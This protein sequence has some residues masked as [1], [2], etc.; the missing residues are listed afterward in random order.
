MPLKNTDE[1]KS[2][3]RAAIHS[4]EKLPDTPF[5]PVQSATEGDLVEGDKQRLGDKNAPPSSRP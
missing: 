3:D 5:S 4:E 2:E 1:T